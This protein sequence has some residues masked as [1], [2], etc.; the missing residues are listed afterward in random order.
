M[1]LIL[2]VGSSLLQLHVNI[3]SSILIK[4]PK[5]LQYLNSLKVQAMG[6]SR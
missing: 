1:S 2:L 3:K 5:L 6:A 4:L